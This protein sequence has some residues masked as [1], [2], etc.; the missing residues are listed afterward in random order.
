MSN[1]SAGSLSKL[2]W[3]GLVCAMSLSSVSLIASPA[4]AG[5]L[6]AGRAW[7]LA[8]EKDALLGL[9]AC[10]ATTAT[11]K[12]PI[13]V[14]LSVSY[15]KD[16][17]AMPIIYLKVAKDPRLTGATVMVRLD[18]KV[19][20]PMFLLAPQDQPAPSADVASTDPAATPVPSPVPEEP[21]VYWY[22]PKDQK[23]LID[24]IEDANTLDLVLNPKDAAP[25]P[26]EVSLSG[27]RMTIAAAESC[28]TTKDASTPFIAALNELLPPKDPIATE[29]TA[30]AL[31]AGIQTAYK[32]YL[33][34]RTATAALNALKKQVE[35]LLA[36]EKTLKER[37][38]DRQGSL[39]R[40]Q[41]R[42]DARRAEA[43]TIQAKID[44]LVAQLPSLQSQQAA[45]DALAAQ[46]K[47]VYDPVKAQI[48]PLEQDVD[49]R[50]SVLRSANNA[51]ASARQSV[52][53]ANNQI[54]WLQNR[55]VEL[56]NAQ[57]R[58][59][60]EVHDANFQLS[61]AQS[62]LSSFNPD[63]EVRRRISSS[64]EHGN[65][66]RDLRDKEQ[67]IRQLGQDLQRAGSEVQSAD[68]ALASCRAQAGAD[69]SGQEQQANAARQREQ[70]ISNER[71]RADQEYR[72]TQQ[73]L[74]DLV[75]RIENDVF[76]ERN[77]L[78]RRVSD[79][80]A[81]VSDLQRQ[82]SNIQSETQSIH[83]SQLPQ[84]Q[85]ALS[86]AR[87]AV[88]SA[89]RQRA[90]AQSE[91]ASAE[92][93]L[94][95]KKAEINFDA[96]EKEY[97]DARSAARS[98]AKAVQDNLD[99]KRRSDRSLKTAIDSVKSQEPVVEKARKERDAAQVPV[100]QIEAQL[101]PFRAQEAAINAQIE[102]ARLVVAQARDVYQ[103]VYEILAN[104]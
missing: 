51:L 103:Q 43:A 45:A 92:S 31:L 44:A 102:A 55:L 2:A 65:L 57:S 80:Q 98:A 5:E 67:R 101:A 41:A 27:S 93:R 37:L 34:G 48:A 40:N 56:Q 13:P 14:E 53:E 38:A 50:E 81:R 87:S 104:Q 39:D 3:A 17:S 97:N 10:R 32:S 71:N 66:E 9:D 68:Q 84:W 59:S 47:A 18:R 8:Q 54:A 73:R 35:P 90:N 96:I 63:W 23:K 28:M 72:F 26:V 33:E 42:L 24:L 100:T 19:F 21:L 11:A 52:Q 25:I 74:Q 70:Q 76:N 20:Q 95:S 77:E 61:R 64:W 99:E 83:S 58:V 15:P 22:A 36:R 94:A 46:K 85:S 89:E 88:V 12:S 78:V 60:S 82:L 62:E 86:Q 91:L 1:V 75:R 30:R 49:R 7:R 69:C 79:A 6:F 16:G 4:L 29:A